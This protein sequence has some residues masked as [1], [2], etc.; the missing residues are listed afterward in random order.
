M[1]TEKE[2][3][4]L[5]D[6]GIVPT[7]YWH[8]LEDGRLQCDLCPRECKLHD[9]QRGLCF[10]RASVEDQIVLTTYGRSSGY[11]IDPIEKKPLNHYLPGTPVLSFGT[12]GCNLACK[13]CQNWD[14]SKSRELDTLMD[15][16][17]PETIARAAEE[18]GCRSVAYTYNDPVIFHEYAIDVAKACRERN[19]KSVAVT[20]G[21]I[22]EEPRKEFF[23]YMDAANVDLKAFTEEFY[24]KVTGSHLQPILETIEYIHHE[25]D[26]W[27]ELTTLLIPGYNDSEKEIEEM[28]QW[29]VEK[30]GP[31]V[32][33][34][35]TAF[36]PEYKL[37]DAP[38]TP[39]AT[40]QRSR[41]IA[42]KNGV[43][44]AYTGNVH[45]KAGDSTYCH[46]CGTRLIERDWYELGEWNLDANGCCTQC[47]TQCAGVFEEGHGDWGSK[48]Q[49][50][51]LANYR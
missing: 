46:S 18:L 50:V 16:A 13:F 29:V 2:H 40:L 23:E 15:Q 51:R 41:D 47:G 17:D 14:I 33:M 19:I 12:A 36:H 21:Y 9:N 24:W 30:L 34:H 20:A 44:Y 39:L 22:S 42:L 26:V 31:D 11:C 43:R 5:G 7:K 49:P 6:P 10:V 37:M 3:L 4:K 28:T 8:K 38:P 45:D 32:P 1:T 25:T 48:R 35:F 27:M